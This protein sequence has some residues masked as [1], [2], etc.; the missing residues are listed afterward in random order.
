M[1]RLLIYLMTCL[2]LTL[3]PDTCIAA[4]DTESIFTI[5][6]SRHLIKIT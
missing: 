6:Q 4:L 5:D 2:E 1:L 3:E